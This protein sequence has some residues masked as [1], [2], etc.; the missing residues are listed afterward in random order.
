MH[1]PPILWAKI[2]SC[3]GFYL[4]FLLLQTGMQSQFGPCRRAMC[5]CVCVC[6]CTCTRSLSCSVMAWLFVTSWTVAHQAP[7]SMRLSRQAYWS[8]L[9]FPSPGDLPDP[10][11][12]PGFPALQANF[13]HLSHRETHEAERTSNKWQKTWREDP[14]SLDDFRE[15]SCFTSLN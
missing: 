9:T 14:G 12:E 2:N 8:G 11:F 4:I 7:L 5:V 10:G 6:V 13:Y 1:L 15:C 3:L